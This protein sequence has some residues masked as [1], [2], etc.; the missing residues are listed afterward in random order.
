MILS[1]CTPTGTSAAPQPSPSTPKA[2]QQQPAAAQPTQVARADRPI[3]PA[4]Q[5][6]PRAVPADP[7]VATVNGRPITRGQIDEPL[8]EGYG[9]NVLLNLAQ[10]E[11]LKQE[12][13]KAGV[14]V[15]PEDVNIEREQTMARMFSDADKS[16]YD[17]L[18]EQFLQQQRISRPEFDIVL[19]SNTYMRKIAEPQLK[20]KVTDEALQEAFRQLYGETVQVRHIQCTNMTEILEA[21]RRLGAGE[22]FEQVAR[23]LSRNE[24]TAGLGGELPAFSRASAGLPQAFKDTAFSLNPGEVSDPVQAEGSFHLIKLENKFPPKAVKFEDVKDSVRQDLEDRL[25]QAAMR[26]M[27]QQIAAQGMATLKIEDVT[28]QRQFEQRKQQRE[29]QVRDREQINKDLERQ[30]EQIRALQEKLA[31][32]V[33][34]TQ[35]ATLDVPI[36]APTTAPATSP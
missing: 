9:L 34:A 10:L 3:E 17:A 32:E 7:V 27:R 23:E 4:P 31:T 20:A 26:Q 8:F 16:D 12:A 28:L 2:A 1:G 33:G 19:T 21:K 30:R 18:F 15:S 25:L 14:V 35:P 29:A 5:L 36:T 13:A 6:P 22:S 24:R 11:L